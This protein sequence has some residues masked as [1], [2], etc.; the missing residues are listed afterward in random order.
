[1]SGITPLTVDQQVHRVLRIGST[2]TRIGI[3]RRSGS[4]RI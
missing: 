3:N 4:I 2:V 1:M